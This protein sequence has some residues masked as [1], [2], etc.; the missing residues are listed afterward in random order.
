M[1]DHDL[2]LL[3]DKLEGREP[4]AWQLNCGHPEQVHLPR[5]RLRDE[6]MGTGDEKKVV[7]LASNENAV[8]EVRSNPDEPEV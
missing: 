3:L 8:D 2:N 4:K 5:F 7:A 1:A 6:L